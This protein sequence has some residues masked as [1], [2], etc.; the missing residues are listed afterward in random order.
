MTRVTGSSGTR[1]P[2]R[3][4]SSRR[5]GSVSRFYGMRALLVLFLVDAV[6]T[7]GYGFDDRTATAV[8]GLYTAA[9]F[10][11]A[12]PGGWIADRLIGAQRAVL[13][14]GTMMTRRQ[15]DAGDS[16]AAAALL[17]G[18][19][20]D[21]A[22]R[23]AAEA[24]HL[25]DGGRSLP[26]GRRKARR[27]LHDLL[28]GDQPR[29]VHRAADRRLARAQVR[30]AHGIPRGGRRNAARHAAVL[31]LARTARQRRHGG[32]STGRR[33]GPRSRLETARRRSRCA[34]RCSLR[35]G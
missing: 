12:L 31:A 9:V 21:R 30:L 25:H 27:G 24:E 35:P 10:M 20:R 7:G 26:R 8:Y 22:G 17:R 1:A 14:G 2:S 5:C 33:R 18:P 16:G 29:R 32:A 4:S 11:A 34:V 28:H 19:R 13:A 3:R 15:P 23:R 6:A